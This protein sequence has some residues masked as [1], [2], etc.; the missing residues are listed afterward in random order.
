M[1]IKITPDR[2]KELAEK[3]NVNEQYLYQCLTGRRDM[4]NA[5]A[6]RVETE[7]AGELTRQMLC[8]STYMDVW[9]DLVPETDAAV[10]KAGDA[11]GYNALNKPSIQITAAGQGA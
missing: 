8:Q 2:R 4:K 6:M 1:E 5:E 11:L 3:H 7:S 10:L 9:P